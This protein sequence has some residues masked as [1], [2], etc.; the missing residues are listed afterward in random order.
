MQF[1][2][3]TWTDGALIIGDAAGFLNSMRLKGIHLAM[4][5]GIY[6][7][8]AAFAAVRAGDVSA[9]KLSHFQDLLNRG[10]VPRELYKVRNV[11]QAFGAG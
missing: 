11:H 8:E 4:K 5:S 2:A 9:I 6:A 1:H 10:S 7:A 3:A